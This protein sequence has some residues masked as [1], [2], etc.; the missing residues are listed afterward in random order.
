MPSESSVAQAVSEIAG[1]F[2]GLLLQPDDAGYDEARRVHN[3]MVDKRPAL[4]AQCRGVADVV[5]AVKLA[6]D[7]GL[8]VPVRGG[9][10][11]VA[12]R[13]DG[14]RRPDDRPVADEGYPR[15]PEPPDGPRARRRNLG[16]PQSRD[17]AA[18]PGG[19]RRRR[20]D[21]R[22]RRADTRRRSSDGSWGS[23]GWLSTIS[24]RSSWSQ[25]RGAFCGRA[26]RKTRICSGPSAAAA[27]ISAW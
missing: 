25:R 20:L 21:H 3:G 14:G 2:S 24:S 8:E 16:R 27:A 11:N 18:R 4:I 12:G 15:R 23:T 19:D 26:P 7:F 5:D 1:T 6:R 22:Y 13:A 17:T 9:G 10:H